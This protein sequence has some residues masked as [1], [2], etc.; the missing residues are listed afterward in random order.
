MSSE[1]EFMQGVSSGANVDH[2]QAGRCKVGS[3]IM[4]KG[5]P[6][7]V[8]DFSTA[9]PGKHGAAKALITGKDIFTGK[10]YGHSFHTG[11]NYPA[12]IVKKEEFPLIMISEEDYLTL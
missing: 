11:D 7:K 5:N 12:P 1:N 6:C 8:T 2:V 9:K 4:I 3:L 10:S